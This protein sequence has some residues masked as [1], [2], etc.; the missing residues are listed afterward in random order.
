MQEYCSGPET[1]PHRAPCSERPVQKTK[2]GQEVI[3]KYKFHS[4]CNISETK[5]GV[6][7]RA[8]ERESARWQG[9]VALGWVQMRS[10]S[11]ERATFK[12]QLGQQSL[13]FRSPTQEE[14]QLCVAEAAQ[15][16]GRV[17]RWPV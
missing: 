6:C 7:V 5:V 9:D 16:C 11:Q 4:L 14:L 17:R 1:R 3:H 15:R 2:D 10:I 8:R 12:L 13:F